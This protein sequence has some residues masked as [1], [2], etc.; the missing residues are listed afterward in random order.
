[1]GGTFTMPVPGSVA[2]ASVILIMYIHVTL[3][4]AEVPYIYIVY[5]PGYLLILSDESAVLVAM[6]GLLPSTVVINQGHRRL[7]TNGTGTVATRS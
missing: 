2:A 7:S 6:N 1:M 5:P 3:A 4:F